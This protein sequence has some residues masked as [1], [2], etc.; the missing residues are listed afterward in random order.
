MDL[1]FNVKGLE[2]AFKALEQLPAKMEKNILRGA[3]RAAA[4][5]V[6]EDARRRAPVLKDADPRRVAGALAKSIRI[7]SVNF[8]QGMLRGGVAA[9]G[10]V[11]VG[12]GKKAVAADAFYA[13]FVEKGTAKMSPRPFLRPAVD[14]K[15]P[16]AIDAATA[17]I[18]GRI[19]AGDLK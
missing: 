16:E 17:Y 5:P 2:E 15:T 3:I 9:G 14:T 18:R 1:E 10:G 7:R 19:D 6:A 11:K 12:R 13:R 4:K 8:I